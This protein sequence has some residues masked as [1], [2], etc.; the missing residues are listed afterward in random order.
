M[1]SA[2]EDPRFEEEISY[3]D[4]AYTT[5]KVWLIVCA[6]PFL[7]ALIKGL[8][9]RD[10]AGESFGKSTH[11]DQSLA[12][13]WG[14]FRAFNESI[15]RNQGI[16]FFQWIATVYFALRLVI[17]FM[18]ELIGL[19]FLWSIRIIAAICLFTYRFFLKLIQRLGSLL[20]LVSGKSLGTSNTGEET[21]DTRTGFYS[22]LIR[23]ALAS[24]TTM[25]VLTASCF[26][27]TYWMGR[28][29]ETELLPEVHQSE[30]TFEVALPVGTPLDQTV[31]IL[32]GVEQ[33]ILKDKEIKSNH[34]AR[35]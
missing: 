9:G 17:S 25:I 32:D 8:H 13:I 3:K 7:I 18:L 33:A 30:F 6:W 35:G 2:A 23:W 31:S 27:L 22:K 11:D 34:N 24:P 15:A 29:L 4:L 20:T 16:F 26:A 14:S 28:Q 21:I 10:D 12:K 19:S 5:F 1:V